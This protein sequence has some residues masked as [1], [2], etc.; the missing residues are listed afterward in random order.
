VPKLDQC[1][2]E[3]TGVGQMDGIAPVGVIRLD[4]PVQV[5]NRVSSQVCAA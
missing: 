1:F 3:P 4:Q 5:A 2:I